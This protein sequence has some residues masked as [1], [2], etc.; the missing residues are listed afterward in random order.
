MKTDKFCLLS[1]LTN[2][3]VFFGILYVVEVSK[4]TGWQLPN[5]VGRFV[6]TDKPTY[7][8]NR[9]VI[10][11]YLF[12]STT[13]CLRKCHRK[14]IL[15]INYIVHHSSLLVAEERIKCVVI[16]QQ[17]DHKIRR[18]S[19]LTESLCSNRRKEN[20]EAKRDHIFYSI[21]FNTPV[22]C[23]TSN[24]PT[25]VLVDL[26][27]ALAK[28]SN[29]RSKIKAKRWNIFTA[30]LSLQWDKLQVW[31]TA[32]KRRDQGDLLSWYTSVLV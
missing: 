14:H 24:S 29:I 1:V 8:M 9:T 16:I 28:K 2:Q 12:F 18:A 11:S 26:F 6:S 13:K 31:F 25:R 4:L 20:G 30:S 15:T 21:L 32:E 27:W 5:F 7:R 23:S 22:N 19:M 17:I 10:I 3:S